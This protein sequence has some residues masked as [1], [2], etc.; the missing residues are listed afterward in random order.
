MRIAQI[1]QAVRAGFTDE[2]LRVRIVTEGPVALTDVL[3]EL[4]ARRAARTLTGRVVELESELI[5]QR[6]SNAWR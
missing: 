3:E 6:A 2:E 4:E 5:V 1:E